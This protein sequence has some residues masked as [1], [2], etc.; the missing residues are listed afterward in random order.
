MYAL[1][2]GLVRHRRAGRAATTLQ[3][4]YYT[5]AGSLLDCLKEQKELRACKCVQQTNL[6]TQPGML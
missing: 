5:Y 2:R 6:E 1:V 3:I 4:Y